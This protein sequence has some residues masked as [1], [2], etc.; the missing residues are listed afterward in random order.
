MKLTNSSEACDPAEV[1]GMLPEG[2]VVSIIK[3]FSLLTFVLSHAVANTRT[4]QVV[5]ETRQVGTW[6]AALLEE[7]SNR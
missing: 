6:N 7:P 2:T 3:V 5:G 1:L 4:A